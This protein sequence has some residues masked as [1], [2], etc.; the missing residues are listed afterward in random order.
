[1]PNDYSP[2]SA[3][4]RKAISLNAQDANILLAISLSLV[5]PYITPKQLM[6]VQ[7][8]LDAAVVN[9]VVKK[10][11]DDL[12]RRSITHR[13]GNLVMR[14]PRME[15]QADRAGEGMIWAK[16]EDKHIRLDLEQLIEKDALEPTTDNPDE[17]EY[18]LKV[19]NTLKEK[20]VWLRVGQERVNDPR[21]FV[22]WLSVGYD[23]EVIPTSAGFNH[24]DRETILGNQLFGARYYEDVLH[25]PIQKALEKEIDR[26]VIKIELGEEEHQRLIRRYDDAFPGIAEVSDALGGADLPSRSIWDHPK[27]LMLMARELNEDGSVMG[28]QACLIAAAIKTR[29]S[30][31]LLATYADKSTQ[32]AA[33]AATIAQVVAVASAVI[34]TVIDV[35]GMARGLVAKEAQSL[36]VARFVAKNPKAGPR[37]AALLKEGEQVTGYVRTRGGSG[38][39][40]RPGAGWPKY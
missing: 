5:M 23:G 19:K 2:N 37:L 3:A 6:Q 31:Q 25:G 34:L 32:G 27:K 24:L 14:D 35:T 38:N 12:S 16:E 30:A 33:M 39:V 8:V 13:A 15:R 1:M 21:S 22:V 9:L 20:G 36:L 29:D 4:R 11:Q 10:E 26:L 40:A 7:K 17:A 28:S 18:L